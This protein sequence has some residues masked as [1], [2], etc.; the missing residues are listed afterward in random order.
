MACR[1]STVKLH[2]IVATIL[3]LDATSY[4]SE[5]TLLECSKANKLFKMH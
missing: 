4:K 2:E 5:Q 1:K 3:L